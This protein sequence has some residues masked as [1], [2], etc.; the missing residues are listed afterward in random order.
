MYVT[1]STFETKVSIQIYAGNYVY[2][3]FAN[4]VTIIRARTF[5]VIAEKVKKQSAKAE[6]NAGAETNHELD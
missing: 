3:W 2:S 4:T 5:R 1:A 6:H